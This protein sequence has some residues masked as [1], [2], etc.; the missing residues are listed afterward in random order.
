MQ[1][2]HSH[3]GLL[4][5]EFSTTDDVGERALSPFLALRNPGVLHGST[6]LSAG[7]ASGR[8]IPLGEPL[9]IMTVGTTCD[10]VA[11]VRRDSSAIAESFDRQVRALGADGQR[12]LSRLCVGIVGLGGIG[13]LVVQQLV[14]LGVRDFVLIDSDIVEATNLN[15]LVGASH[16]DIGTPKV[17]IAAR[18]IRSVAPAS[19]IVRHRADVVYS[20]VAR[21]VAD[22]DFIFGCTDSHG[23]RALLQQVCYQFLVPYID[24]GTT[25]VVRDGTVA[26]IF[27]RIQMLAPGLACFACDGLL[28]ANEVR[29]DMMLESERAR[30]PY[31]V[32]A[33]EPAPAVISYNSTVASLGVTMFLS[34]VTGLPPSARHQIYNA[35]TSTLRSVRATPRENCYICSPAGALARGDSWPLLGRQD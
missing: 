25:I 2:V 8:V 20:S 35:A 24:M 7:G 34:A 33:R 4:S 32:G 6:I 13:S 29:R 10:T 15:R 23:S 1:F 26:G 9:E 3:P 16:Q 27:G 11:T 31:L 17:D 21:R 22:V 5:P 12:E 30:D 28:D 18:L 19:T 14:H